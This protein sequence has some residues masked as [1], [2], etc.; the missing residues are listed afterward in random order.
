[1]FELIESFELCDI[2]RIR[3]P[4]EKCF[5]LRQNH[6]SGYVQWRLDYFFVSNK[7]QESIKNTDILTS[8]SYNYSPVSFTLR[9]SQIIVKGRGLWIFNSSLTLNKEFVQR[10]KE[11]IS[12]CLN[13]LEKEN[14]LDVPIRWEILKYEL[15][16]FFIKFSKGQVRKLRLEKVLLEKNPKKLG[17]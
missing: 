2:W 6:I 13:H 17:K 1:M 4:T 8:L 9:K 14:I 7:L 15:R 12:T 10:M 5:T 16:K 3:Y 11:H